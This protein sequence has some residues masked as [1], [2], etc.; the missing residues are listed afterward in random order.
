MGAM[1]PTLGL[2]C[3]EQRH[4]RAQLGRGDVP[5]VA[6]LDLDGDEQAFEAAEGAVRF[7]QC[8]EPRATG[9]FRLPGPRQGCFFWRDAT[10]SIPGERG[11]LL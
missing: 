11:R 6:A 2:P 9:R 7:R 5:L 3:H 8:P 10:L 4:Q 1:L